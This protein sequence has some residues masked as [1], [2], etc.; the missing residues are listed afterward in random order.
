MDQV[1]WKNIIKAHAF[2]KNIVTETA[3]GSSLLLSLPA[4][5]PWKDTL[6]ELVSEK[7][8]IETPQNKLDK[9]ECP[10]EEP[11]AFLLEKYCKK[12]LRAMYR[13]GRSYAQFLGE[14]QETVLNNRYIWVSDIPAEKAAAWLTFVSEYTQNVKNNTPGIFILEVHDDAIARRSTRGIKNLCFNQNISSYDKYAFCALASSETN[15]KEFLRPYLAEAVSSVCGE[16]VE[17]CAAC[18]SKGSEF[19]MNPYQTIQ[20]LI[21]ESLRSNE[22]TYDFQKTEADVT[23]LIWEAQLKYVFPLIEN[24]R[25][26]FISRHEPL[27]RAA[28]PV[29][30][31]YGEKVELPQEAETGTLL[32]LVKTGKLSISEKEHAEL[33]R[34]QKAR[35]KLAHM[36]IL[37]QEELFE[38]LRAGRQ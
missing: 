24:Y 22:E 5:V 33:E 26:A 31:S 13:R 4:S 1:W 20:K 15:C 18:V 8:Q 34:Y 12:E 35:N 11:G 38:I 2:L 36:K 17:L 32:H 6:I 29:T 28:L 25:K 9:I 16:D 14:C 23:A 19:L 7:L 30:N 3:N 21:T 37:E 10:S 27:I